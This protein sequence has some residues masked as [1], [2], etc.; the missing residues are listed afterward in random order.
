MI[1]FYSRPQLVNPR[2]ICAFAGWNDG[3]EAATSAARYLRDRWQ[4]RRF[5][6]IEP[7]EFFDFSVVRPN[8]RLEDGVTRRV[9]WP[10]SEFFHA[11]PEGR[12]VIVFI[13]IEPNLRW[14]TF[15]EMFVSTLEG[16]GTELVVTL[17][18]FLANVPH[19]RE[20]PIT[21]SASD[22]ELAARLGL[23]ASR[24]EGPTGVVGVLHDAAGRAGLE[25]VSIWAAVPHYLPV[26][27]NP[28]A[29][30][31]LVERVRALLEISIPTDTLE[32]SAA[33]WEQGVNALAAESPELRAFIERLEA[34]AGEP[35]ELGP[36]PTGD[37]LAA[38]L[39]RF[40]REQ[41]GKDL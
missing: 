39:E 13:G 6:S 12:D 9:E 25:S 7:E 16:L 10:A 32:R 38:E 4:A 41:D 27:P 40:L 3:G 36:L 15:T 30:L 1:D 29:A 34:A 17:G 35:E 26:A 24:Y 19:T 23:T 28:R 31:A 33:S 21:G 20:S 8:V 22:P 14:K 18:A 11:S 37:Q 2:A 5:A